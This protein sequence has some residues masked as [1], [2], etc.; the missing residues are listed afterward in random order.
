VPHDG[1]PAFPRL[2]ETPGRPEPTRAPAGVF[3]LEST[4]GRWDVV[5]QA[6]GYLPGE[7]SDVI[8]PRPDTKP[9]EL[10]LSHGPSITGLA[11][12]DNNLGVA[13]IPMFLKVQK[14]AGDD[15]PPASSIARTDSTGR[16][17]F[18]PLPAG[19]YTV[20]ALEPGG[21]DH[22]VDIALERG[23]AEIQVYVAPRHQ[24]TAA[25]R[26]TDGRP[27]ADAE[28]ELRSVDAIASER[29]NAAGQARLRFLKPGHYDVKV[30]HEGY[31]ELRD[32][33]DLVGPSGEIV[34]WFTVLAA[35]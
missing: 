16:F 12:D 9:L 22:T 14:L 7:L 35:P 13:D 4:K 20:S 8:I 19:V 30:S 11:F 10:R 23:T 31:A 24:L 6:A 33:L 17:R 29:T 32:T 5:V 21:L 28:V 26:D 15:P 27:V 3:H 34:R 18:S 2:S 1:R 25:V